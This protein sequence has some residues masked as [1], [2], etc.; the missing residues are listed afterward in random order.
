M[1]VYTLVVFLHIAA[2]VLLL[3]TS[4]VG[5]PLVRS[6]VRRATGVHELRAFLEIGRP[7]ARISPI[8]A[9]LVF[10]T[11]MYLTGQA[12]LWALGWVQAAIAFWF[13]NAVVAGA[14]VRRAVDALA[15]AAETSDTLVGPHVDEL[16]WAS[17]WTWGLDVLAVTDAVT[18][19]IM[20]LKPSL[21]GSLLLFLLA[22]AAM[23]G[24]RRAFSAQR[25]PLA[26]AA[27]SPGGTEA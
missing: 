5:E 19:A 12:R 25:P 22:H 26:P 14:V 17:G 23:A 18:L 27:A 7:M 13:I 20:T 15:A 8:A 24:A 9:V 2:A 6:A 16:R 3:A 1:S 10:A 11:G 4:I 21:G